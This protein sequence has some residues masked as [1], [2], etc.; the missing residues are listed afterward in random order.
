MLP[1]H[2][3]EPQKD[4]HGGQTARQS[5]LECR[6]GESPV[7]R[8][9]Y[10]SLHCIFIYKSFQVY[11]HHSKQGHSRKNAFLIKRQNLRVTRE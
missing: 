7:E 6:K 11:L 3:G 8:E 9:K 5:G 1:E 4:K 10:D 2:A